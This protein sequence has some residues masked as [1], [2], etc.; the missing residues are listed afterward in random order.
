MEPVKPDD[1][2]NRVVTFYDPHPGFLGAA[3]PLPGA[4]KKVVD[5]LDGKT[6]SLREAVTKF[7]AVTGG[8]ITV[9]RDCLFLRLGS[10]A[11]YAAHVFR[12]IRYK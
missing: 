1:D 11:N 12:L 7:Q 3:S 6:M 8:K 2:L 9:E 10:D 4:V 5:E